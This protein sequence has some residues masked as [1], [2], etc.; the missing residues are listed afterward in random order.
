MATQKKRIGIFGGTFDPIHAGHLI[1]AEIALTELELDNILFIPA[2]SP[3]HKL[4]RQLSPPEIRKQLVEA[5]IAGNPH[6]ELSE[7]EL[8]R[9]ENNY[10]VDTLAELSADSAFQN[11]DFFLIIGADNFITFHQWHDYR[12]ILGMAKLAVYP[13]YESDLSQASRDLQQQ[14]IFFQAPRMEIS[15]SFI[16]KLVRQR[17]AITYLVP[18]AVEALIAELGLYRTR[19]SNQPK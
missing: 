2:A 10:M 9:A 3:P 19:T 16:R 13:R 14:A 17:R 4:G 7:I 1:I 8:E 11:A 12:R 15:S 6:F 5:A 18:K